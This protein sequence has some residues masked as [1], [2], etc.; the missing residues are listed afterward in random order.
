MP[1]LLSLPLPLAIMTTMVMM[2]DPLLVILLLVT[3]VVLGATMNMKTMAMMPKMPIMMTM[4][5]M[6]MMPMI[7]FLILHLVMSPPLLIKVPLVMAPI[8]K[9]TTTIMRTMIIHLPMPLL[10]LALQ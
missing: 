10:L 5:M 9:R 1:L 7:P 8:V 3:A 2:C 6:P 4:T